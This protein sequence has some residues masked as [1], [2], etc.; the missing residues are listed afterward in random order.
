[1]K[2][3]AILLPNTFIPIFVAID[4]FWL[5]P[6]FTSYTGD[7]PRERRRRVI[8]QSIATAFGVSVAFT[9]VGEMIFSLL[10]ISVNDF[11]V[12]G[13][14][15]LLVLAILDL[16]SAEY[17]EKLM[18]TETIG[19]VPIGVP[20]IVGPALLT[21]CLVLV[22]HYGILPTMVSLLLNLILVWIAFSAAERI[23]RV[24]GSGGIGALSKIMAILLASI[25]V[26]MVRLGI[27]GYLAR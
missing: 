4:L 9:L 26:M 16:T 24:L 18:A 2:D 15:L 22:D 21:T 27:E 8:R 19:V 1:M 17:K 7:M 11:K 3:F 6:I 12:A 23:I 13:G 5:L 25:A 10:G 20:L 14:T